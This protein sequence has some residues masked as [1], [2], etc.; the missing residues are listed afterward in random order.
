MEIIFS[1]GQFLLLQHF[2]TGLHGPPLQR[3]RHG[4][5]AALRFDPGKHEL[6]TAFINCLRRLVTVANHE[7]RPVQAVIGQAMVMDCL[8]PDSF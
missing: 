4:Q 7:Q 6:L 5:T 1:T 8:R 2:K 3:D